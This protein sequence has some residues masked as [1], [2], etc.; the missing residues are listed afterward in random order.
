MKVLIVGLGSIAQKHLS[1]LRDEFDEV[2][3][4]ALRSGEGRK[5][6]EGV[7]NLY[8]MEQ[9]PKELD[10]AIIS[11]PT[12]EHYNTIKSLAYYKLPLLIEKPILNSLENVDLLKNLIRENNIQTYVACNLRFHP[13][14]KILKAEFEKRTP[15][16]V[17]I[18]CGSYLPDWRPEQDYRNVYSAQKELGGGVNL[19]LIHEIDYTTYLMG[20]PIDTKSYFH[21][22]SGLEINSNDVAHYILEYPNSSVFITL[23]YYRR[24]AKR[25][26]ECVWE[27]ET[28]IADLIKGVMKKDNGE[29]IFEERFDI[30]QT[31]REQL[32]YFW[33]K[34]SNNRELMND[35]DEAV[36]V[37]KICLN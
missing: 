28:W 27:N 29:I 36:E 31:Y 4:Y 13:L 30:M 24:Q 25:E 18:Y 23:N 10:F 17:N 6:L 5:N 33:T 7:E 9:M 37:L 16:E 15:I 12:S 14:I 19:D 22:K 1:A 32:Q 8:S 21:K 2:K 11:N 20:L 35:L 34:V 26:I 3:V